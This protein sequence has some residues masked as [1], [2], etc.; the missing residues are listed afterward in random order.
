MSI[1]YIALDL[2]RAQQKVDRLAKELAQAGLD[3]QDELQ[4]ELREAEEDLRLLR[5][6]LDGA[7]EP[8]PFRTSFK[9]T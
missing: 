6:M 5:R 3:K 8:L 9:K 1:K 7:K 2:Y 4:R